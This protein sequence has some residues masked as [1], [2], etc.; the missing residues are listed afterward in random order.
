MHAA[1]TRGS[2]RDRRAVKV[3]A[4]LPRAWRRRPPASIRPRLTAVYG[5]LFLAV[6]TLLLGITYAL[7][8]RRFSAVPPRLVAP[9]RPLRD[10]LGLGDPRARIADALVKQ[11]SEALDQLLAQSALALAIGSVLALACGWLMAGRVLAPLRDIT[12]VARRLSTRN[13]DERINLDGPRDEL[14]RL[15]DTFD[16]MLGLLADAF[17]AQRRFH[18]NVS[19]ELRTPLTVQRA[20]VDVALA[21]P[22]PSV[23]S[24]R[25]MA[26]R[27]RAA[28]SR[29]ERLIAGL[30]MLARSERGIERYEEVDLAE[31]VR[32]A[33]AAV[34]PAAGARGLR[35]S[36]ELSPCVV[37]GDRM[38]LE[39]L[40]SNLL[41]NAVRHNE[42]GGWIAVGVSWGGGGG[43]EPGPP[44]SAAGARPNHCPAAAWR[45]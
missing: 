26:V 27:V 37:P 36:A 18:A 19:H 11:R 4:V 9:L 15:A 44:F 28:A 13:L 21:D 40:V 30:L 8:E 5:G 31:V 3:P 1:A 10:P 22:D 43:R 25:T 38:L 23:E 14:K 7:F 17:E 42:Q 6:G 45:S 41:D 34:G 33:L 12:A 39:R 16:A 20:A 24:L 35:I 2:V 32:E 29:Q